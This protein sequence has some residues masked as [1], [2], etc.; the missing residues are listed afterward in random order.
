MRRSS[1]FRRIQCTVQNELFLLEEG[2]GMT[3]LP[4]SLS[5]E[6]LFNPKSENWSWDLY[7]V[8]IKVNENLTAL[9]ILILWV[10]NCVKHFRSLEGENSRTRTEF[11]TF[12]KALQCRFIEHRTLVPNRSFCESAQHL[13]SS[14]KLVWAIRFDRRRKGTRQNSR[15]RRM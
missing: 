14:F 1:K 12:V 4:T 11:N 8:M 7:V 5:K 10:Q 3:F 6:T 9:F 15:Q 2:S 13:R